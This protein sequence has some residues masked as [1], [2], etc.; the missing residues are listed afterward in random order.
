MPNAMSTNNASGQRRR[1]DSR[2]EWLLSCWG[3]FVLVDGCQWQRSH[4]PVS[5]SPAL[6]R[7]NARSARGGAT[8][9]KLSLVPRK[10]A[11]IL[12]ECKSSARRISEALRDV[13]L[14]RSSE[15]LA[16]SK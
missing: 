5:M 7:G 2:S 16:G 11:E 15:G 10:T 6:T 3:M 9:A 8:L 1:N 14:G 13:K 12:E 4:T